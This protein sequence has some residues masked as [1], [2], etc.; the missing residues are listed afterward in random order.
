MAEGYWH[1]HHGRTK[2]AVAAFEKAWLTSW[3]NSYLVTY[4]SWVLTDYAAALRLHAHALK[5]S[6]PKMEGIVRRRWHKIATWANYVSLAL[7]PER[8]RA[9]RELALVCESRGQIKK[10]WKLADKSCRKAQETRSEYEYAKSLL[11]QGL[12]GKKLGRPEAEEQILKAQR[13]IA[14]LE[15]AIAI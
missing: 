9:L 15:K 11:V 3:A 5:S 12:T 8:P 14:R 10:A 2:N 7:P 6:D 1:L 4:N 13:D